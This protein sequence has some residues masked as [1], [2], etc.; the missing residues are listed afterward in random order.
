MKK[1]L[2]ICVHNSARSQMAEALL[3]QHCGEFFQVASAGM[4]PGTLNPLAVQV[5]NEIGI[6][7]SQNKTKDI[8]PFIRERPGYNYVISVCDQSV[9]QHCPSFPA[10]VRQIEWSFPDPAAFTGTEEEKLAR[11]RE[12]RDAIKARIEAWCEEMCAHESVT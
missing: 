9:G 12:V 3:K 1:V 4:R 10:G 6:D 8:F 5:M 11:T 2:F 7:I